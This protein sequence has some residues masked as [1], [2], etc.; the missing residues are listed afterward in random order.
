MGEKGTGFGLMITKDFV[1]MN[2]GEI[3]CNSEINKGTEFIL[4]FKN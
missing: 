3:V 1:E 4:S 2:G